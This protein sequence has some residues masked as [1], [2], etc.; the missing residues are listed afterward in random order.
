MVV[1]V[2]DPRLVASDGAGRLDP[3]NQTHSGQGG[4]Y[5]IHRLPRHLGQGGTHGPEDRL[6][7]GMRTGVDGLQ[8]RQTRA[9]HAKVSCTEL[10]RVIRCRSHGTNMAPFLESVKTCEDHFSAILAHRISI[11]GA[12]D[13]SMTGTR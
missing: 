8:H 10:I 11:V 12:Y 1:V 7:V 2:T 13:H 6:G 9:S 3:P 5:V 4:E